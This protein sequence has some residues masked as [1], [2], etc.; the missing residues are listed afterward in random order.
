MSCFKAFLT[1]SFSLLFVGHTFDLLKKRNTLLHL[2]REEM[3]LHLGLLFGEFFEYLKA[4]FILL[5]VG[6]N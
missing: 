1:S 5:F 3:Q 6:F 2:H 4:C